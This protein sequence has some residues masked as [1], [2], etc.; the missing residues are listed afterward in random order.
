MIASHMVHAPTTTSSKI[1]IWSN[2]QNFNICVKHCTIK[3]TLHFFCSKLQISEEH[4]K[5]HADEVPKHQSDGYFVY[6][7][8]YPILVIKTFALDIDTVACKNSA[9]SQV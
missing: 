9:S 2:S 8:K 5:K 7:D 1:E 4:V 6:S 3:R